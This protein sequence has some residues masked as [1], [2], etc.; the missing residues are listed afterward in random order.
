[1]N[2]RKRTFHCLIVFFAAM[3]LC[4][5]VETNDVKYNS[6]LHFL[7]GEILLR[8]NNPISALYEFEKTIEL[9]KG[10]VPAYKELIFLYLQSGKYEKAQMLVK[11]LN[12]ISDNVDTKLFLG[13]YYVYAGDTTSAINQYQHV[14]KKEPDNAEAILILAGIYSEISPEKSL[15]YW[16]KYI[17]LKPDSAD[18]YYR[19]AVVLKK[20]NKIEEAKE[21]V[22]K[23][24]EIQPE[25]ILSHIMLAEIYENE[26]EYILAGD[27]LYFCG[28]IDKNSYGYYIRAGG[29]YMLAKEYEKSEKVF[30]EAREVS[31][32]DPAVSFWL[33]ILYEN[34]RDWKKAS[35]YVEESL[36]RK[37]DTASYVKLSYYYT[38][39]NDVKKAIKTLGQALKLDPKSADVNFFIGLG[40][41]DLK[42]SNKAVKYF[43]RTID[44]NPE[45]SEAYYYLG[46]IYEQSGKFDK[47][48][49]N[50]RKVVELEPKNAVAMN[51]L[52][53]CLA[54]RGVNLDEAETLIRNALEIDPEN[55]A[56]RDSLGWIYFKKGKYH[57]AK[58]EIEQ[59]S[60]NLKDPVIYE[61]L[62]D[63]EQA[64]GNK[65]EAE[66]FYKKVI[67]LEP[68]NKSAKKKLK[69][70]K[71]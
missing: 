23:A 7:Q 71:L 16:D 38:Q 46:T 70:I 39:M 54:D 51:Y 37:P 28:G 55:G 60:K 20:L 30:L 10:A 35:E 48:L 31:K 63:I 43:R 32:N 65:K 4:L 19:K 40:Y 57:E 6:H 2:L 61:H 44:L 41:M 69:K 25:D 67:F 34:K 50:L 68:K 3:P 47:A 8:Q 12:N 11:I 27:E 29:M 58:I 5:A 18:A 59:A 24:I 62:G 66:I 64:L 1:M 49:P 53:Y 17:R 22:N 56:Y 13:T 15:D 42:E 45:R 21:L 52:G 33:G 36:A 9:D 26:Q 14:L